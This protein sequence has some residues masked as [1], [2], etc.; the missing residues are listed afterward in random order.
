MNTEEQNEIWEDVIGYE[1]YY[2]VSNYGRVKSLQRDNRYKKFGRLIP[3]TILKPQAHYKNGYLSV[4]FKIGKHQKRKTVHSLV[5]N[6][7]IENTYDLLEVNH[8]D[9]NKRNNNYK[10]LEWCTRQW[11]CKHAVLNGLR[12]HS[13]IHQET[14]AIKDLAILSFRSVLKCA[15]YLKV[16]HRTIRRHIDVSK[17]LNGYFIYS[18]PREGL[19]A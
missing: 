16:S 10:N 7:F 17:S 15:E 1:S 8:R 13:C 19:A 2:Q 5:A 12:E 9:T 18:I 3:E 4:L 6:A 14:I 11:N